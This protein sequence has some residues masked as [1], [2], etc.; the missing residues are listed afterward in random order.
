MNTSPSAAVYNIF[1]R[2][3]VATDMTNTR[4]AQ[5]KVHINLVSSCS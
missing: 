2:F 1:H 3:R 4:D 5:E